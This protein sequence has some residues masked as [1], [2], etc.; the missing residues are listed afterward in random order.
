[1][2][3]A[4]NQLNGVRLLFFSEYRGSSWTHPADGTD[5]ISVAGS[6]ADDGRLAL[7]DNG[8][9]V[10]ALRNATVFGISPR[11]RFDLVVNLMTL[12]AF[13]LGRITVMGGGR[14]W[15]PLVHVKDVARAFATQLNTHLRIR[16]NAG[17]AYRRSFSVS[18]RNL[19]LSVYGPRLR[20]KRLG[21]G[22]EARVL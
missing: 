9:C 20:R 21:L 12:H 14:Q 19:V 10:S 3:V 11:M 8:F 7:A 18:D 17:F 22:F 15:R 2:L 4:W 13:E 5:Y 6:H 16:K 1:M